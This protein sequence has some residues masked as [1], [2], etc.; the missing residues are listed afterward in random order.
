MVNYS[1]FTMCSKNYKDAYDF[2]IDS[3]L[4]TS[5]K[6]IYIYTDD[7]NWKSNNDRITIINL[8]DSISNDWLVNTGR[9][10]IAAKDFI[11]KA[12][13]RLV[14]LDIDCY[15][16]RDIG[17]VFE[18]YDFDFAVTRLIRPRIDVSAGVYF[19]Y[20]TENNRKFF[21]EWHENQKLNYKRGKGVTAYQGSYA[22][23]AFSNVI[24]GYHR[25]ESHKVIDLDVDIY[26]RKTGKP[27]QIDSTI[28][29]LKENKIEILH[30]YARTWRN[31]DV[32][33]IIPYLNTKNINYF[34]LGAYNGGE[35]KLFMDIC[36]RLNITN[37]K[38][39][40]FEPNKKMYKYLKEMFTDKR[41]YI[42]DKAI[43]G[44]NK[45]VKLYHDG[46]KGQGDS[47]FSTKINININDYDEVDGVLFSDWALNNVSNFKN[48]F[49][50]V[51]F[52]IE[53][54]EWFLM[55]D[56][57]NSGILKYIDIFSG[58]P[59]GEDILKVS[60]L[61]DRVH[62][63]HKLLKDNNINIH[64]FDKEHSNIIGDLIIKGIKNG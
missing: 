13:E 62:E 58:S 19:F 9:R 36:S 33:K 16:I 53:G 8:F 25:T 61:K 4:R 21:D 52:N 14:F 41:I 55:K 27:P 26:N 47:I 15:L 1:I 12:G 43:A 39:Y 40:C 7:P 56:V 57:V 2:V 37:Y 3:W 17:H 30:F 34:D 5:V 51:R 11:K 29:D 49:N 24:R 22:Q 20:N 10:V 35:V 60:E 48:D 28:K 63:H 23:L 54:A 44:E 31:K 59:R 46:K 42:L 50:I 18:D 6:N 32:D 45:T 64:I 38:I